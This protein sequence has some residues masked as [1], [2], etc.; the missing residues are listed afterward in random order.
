MALTALTLC[1]A[2]EGGARLSTPGGVCAARHSS[3]AAVQMAITEN[4]GLFGSAESRRAA[5]P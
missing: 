2:F 3:A 1:L 5:A 4:H